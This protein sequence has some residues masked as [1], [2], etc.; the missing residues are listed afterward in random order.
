MTNATNILD[1][2]TLGASIEELEGDGEY[3]REFIE[4]TLR[5]GMV[6]GW[7]SFF[8]NLNVFLSHYP[9]DIW[10]RNPTPSADI[11]HRAVEK[12]REARDI[13]AEAT[14]GEGKR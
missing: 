3:T 11:G 7:G 13:N 10:L 5:A 9:E 4:E 2:F 1:A 8:C 14:Q 12:L 6:S